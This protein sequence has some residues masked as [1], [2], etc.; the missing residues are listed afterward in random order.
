MLGDGKSLALDKLQPQPYART[1][2]YLDD[3]V[4]LLAAVRRALRHSG[5]RV[6][7]A[8]SA[9]EAFEILATTE[10]GVILCDQRMRGMSGTEFLSR[11]KQMY[12]NAV[13]MVLSG[14]TDLHSVTDSVNHGAIFKFLTKPW[15]EEELSAALRDAFAEFES[16]GG[17][18]HA[19][20]A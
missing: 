15:I 17:G 10:V 7:T 5:Y 2:L 4:N 20:Q 16:K 19:P 13:R 11:V 6:L 8:S 18:A 14:Y 1:L 9:E 12:P 3:E